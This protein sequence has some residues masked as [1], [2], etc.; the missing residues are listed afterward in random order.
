MKNLKFYRKF[1][2]RLPGMKKLIFSVLLLMFITVLTI[3]VSAQPV[4]PYNVSA[5]VMSNSTTNPFVKVSWMYPSA[6][7]HF[8][9]Y[10]KA[11]G[12]NDTGTFVKKFSNVHMMYVNDYNVLLNQTYSYY[13]TAL[14][15]IGESTPSDTVQVTVVFTPLQKAIVSGIVTSDSTNLPII[16]A[17]VR[18]IST[19]SCGC[20]VYYTNN[21]GQFKAILLPGQYYV[22][23]SKTGFA[24]EYYD[25]KPDI[26][27][28]D[29]IILA[30]ND[31]IGISIGLNPVALAILYSITG[32]VKDS[33]NQPIISKVYA[34]RVRGNNIHFYS[35]GTITDSLGNYTLGVRGG[36]TVV[37]YASPLNNQYLPEYWDNK[38]S[39][40]EADKIYVN[41]NISNINF[42]LE[43]RFV[44][45]NGI[46]G[47]VKDTA[48]TVG[49][50]SKIIAYKYGQN[51]PSV[52]SIRTYNVLSDSSGN[53]MFNNLLPGKYKL[54]AK[55]FGEYRPTYFRYDHV[56][57]LCWQLADSVVVDSLGIVSN[58]DFRVIPLPDTGLAVINGTVKTNSGSNINGAIVY[59]IMNNEIVNFAISDQNGHYRMEGLLPGNYQI[60]A[61]KF[62]YI[63]Q[64]T[65]T[66]TVDYNTNLFQ[67]LAFT[68]TP[69][70]V[71]GIIVSTEIPGKF[72]LKQN[73]PNPFNPSTTIGFSLTEKSYVTL[74]VFDAIGREV[75]MLVNGNLNT[76]TYQVSFDGRNLTSGVYFYKLTA[77][78]FA[79]TK[80]MLLIK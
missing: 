30:N 39:L 15:S 2:Y 1:S 64:N 65:Y 80:R 43:H 54:L 55:P 23:T 26:Q 75:T 73:Y 20:N 49:V 32:T 11:G 58:I 57:T 40:L 38:R 48:N 18:F 29:K 28:A 79:E 35:N 22:F 27:S 74:K 69:D 47:Q 56:P 52:T 78:N 16:G 42:I 33:V 45:S 61:D 59:A 66:I 70:N 63:N 7:M 36:D 24:S 44:Y 31:S 25:N 34:Y 46:S 77:G 6:G 37:V 76:G 10:R 17:M 72:E 60:K 8:N 5:V 19:S 14:S 4:P 51:V 62:N 53:Y 68:L 12:L 50:M 67:T 41:G 9:V 21:L 13:V 3:P 71:T